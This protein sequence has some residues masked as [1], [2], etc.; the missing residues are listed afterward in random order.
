[1]IYMSVVNLLEVGYHFAREKT[2]T[3]MSGIWESIYS[4]P[5]TFVSKISD[6][7]FHEAVRLKARYR[8]SVGDV[9]GLA[10][11]VTLGGSFVTSD[12]HDIEAVEKNEHIP[13][14]WLPP[15]PKK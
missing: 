4:L 15:R 12:H 14:L 7:V 2:L 3:E 11:A 10:T 6:A 13:I 1:M 5:I 8:V 9:F